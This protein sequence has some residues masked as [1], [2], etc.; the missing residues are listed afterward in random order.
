MLRTIWVFRPYAYGPD[1]M[2][3]TYTVR[4]YVYDRI[5][6]VYSYGLVFL[7][8]KKEIKETSL[9]SHKVLLKYKHYSLCFKLHFLQRHLIFLYSYPQQRNQTIRVRSDRIGIY[10]FGPGLIRN[11][12]ILL[13]RQH[14]LLV[15]YSLLGGPSSI[16]F[17]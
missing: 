6:L 10:P 15:P 17:P 3:Y 8:V 9:N 4:P 14:C 12:N 11:I 5:I 7:T 16:V 13:W 2:V 1:R